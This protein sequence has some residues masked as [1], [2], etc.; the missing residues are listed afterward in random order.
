RPFPCTR[1]RCLPPV[2]RHFVIA[3]GPRGYPSRNNTRALSY[4][5]I[6]DT[7]CADQ[8]SISHRSLH[9]DPPRGYPTLRRTSRASNPIVILVV[10][11]HGLASN[12]LGIVLL[13]WH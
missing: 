9:A 8:R 6:R 2:Q 4:L 1:C 10:G 5:H 13:H 3:G 12:F 11:C 7:R